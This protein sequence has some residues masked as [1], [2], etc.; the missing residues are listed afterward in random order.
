MST[1]PIPSDTELVDAARELVHAEMVGLRRLAG[2][3]DVGLVDLARQLVAT[4]GKVITAG[5]GTSGEIARRMAHLLTVTGT[6]S[7][8]LHPAD[9]LHGRLGVVTKHDLVIALSKG[10]ETSELNEFVSRARERGANVVAVT[11]DA[12]SS[13][14]REASTTVHLSTNDEAEPGGV[15]AM[16]STL[17]VA[18]WGDALA[19]V[20]MKLRRY[21]W[22]EVLFTHPGG[23]VGQLRVEDVKGVSGDSNSS[24]QGDS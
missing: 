24:R 6:P 10:G 3:I 1:R 16:G 23:A 13:F 21:D 4:R 12:S 11:G 15:I 22:E 19:L 5:L 9:G 8:F 18:A 20:T 14:S 7:F 17:A 2:Q